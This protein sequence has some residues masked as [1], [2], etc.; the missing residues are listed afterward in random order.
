[1]ALVLILGREMADREKI[2]DNPRSPKREWKKGDRRT[3]DGQ[4][5]VNDGHVDDQSERD[6][7]K[8]PALMRDEHF[9]VKQEPEEK[10][11]S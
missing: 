2:Y 4:E 7:K 6:L 9:W 3:I 8:R 1:M 5:Y 10:P 11:T